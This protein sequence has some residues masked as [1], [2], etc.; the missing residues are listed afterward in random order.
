MISGH[1]TNP[2]ARNAHTA[3]TVMVIK[4]GMSPGFAVIDNKLYYFDKTLMVLG[5]TKTFAS[6]LVRPVSRDKQGPD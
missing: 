6:D 4:R 5:D 1:V 2:A 3:R